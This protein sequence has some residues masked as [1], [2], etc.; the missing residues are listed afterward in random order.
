MLFLPW[1]FGVIPKNLLQNQVHEHPVFSSNSFIVLA[2]RLLTDF[3]YF[4]YAMKSSY[5]FFFACGNAPSYPS[6][7]YG[8]NHSFPY[9]MGL[10]PLLESI[11]HRGRFWTLNT[12]LLPYMS[13]FVLVPNHDVFVSVAS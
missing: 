8:R 12:I 7:I 3:D 11:D 2:L 9:G 6:T 13:V 5:S 1:A 10:A 4:V